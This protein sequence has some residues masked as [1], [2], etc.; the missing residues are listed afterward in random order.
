MGR[1]STAEKLQLRCQ[2][3]AELCVRLGPVYLRPDTVQTQRDLLETLVGAAVWYLPNPKART[4]TGHISVEAVKACSA[5]SG[6][7]K[8]ALSEEHLFPRKI[9]GAQLLRKDWADFSDPTAHLVEEFLGRLGRFCYVTK[10]ENKR[11]V[12]LQRGEH[13]TGPVECYRAAGLEFVTATC[14]QLQ[15]LRR[16]KDT[17]VHELLSSPRSFPAG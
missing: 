14:K 9:T 7:G 8:V 17:I 4:W 5:E 16:R 3:I 10:S 11:L 2:T 15:Q 6:S 12:R 13:F 1:I